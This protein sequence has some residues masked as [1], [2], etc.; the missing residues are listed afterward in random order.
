MAR[1]TLF[2]C[3]APSTL[4]PEPITASVA[5]AWLVQEMPKALPSS[6]TYWTRR[7]AFAAD[8]DGFSIDQRFEIPSEEANQIGASIANRIT[9]YYSEADESLDK[10]GEAFDNLEND[11]ELTEGFAGLARA[12]S[13][14]RTVNLV[15]RL[16]DQKVN[17]T[18]AFKRWTFDLSLGIPFL[19]PSETP[20]GFSGCQVLPARIDQTFAQA[21]ENAQRDLYLGE[22]F[23]NYQPNL[24]RPTLGFRVAVHS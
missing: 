16:T 2:V 11:D 3:L 13:A 17:P 7:G 21:V 4:R 9:N 18:A 22:A 10:L 14:R 8:A 20:A 6:A 5:E 24:C 12:I 23:A 19:A 15:N 1:T